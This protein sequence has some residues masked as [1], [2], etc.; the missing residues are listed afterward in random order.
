MLR[1][2]KE[3]CHSYSLGIKESSETKVITILEALRVFSRLFQ[4]KLMV[5]SDYSKCCY[6]GLFFRIGT[7]EI[8]LFT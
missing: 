7:H 6:L 1:I 5:E 3:R 8:S 4:G 2:V